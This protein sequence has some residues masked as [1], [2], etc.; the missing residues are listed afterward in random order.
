MMIK[1]DARYGLEVVEIFPGEYHAT[2]SSRIISTVLGS[3][4]AVALFDRTQPIAGM[5]HFMLPGDLQGERIYATGSGKYGMYAM[6][7]LINDMIKLGGKK[8]NFVAKV[9]GGGSVLRSVSGFTGSIPEGN[10]KFSLTYLKQENIPIAT[11][12]VGGTTGRR[13]LYFTGDHKV[14]VRKLSS[15]EVSPVENEEKV[16]LTKIRKEE[17]TKPEIVLF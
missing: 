11:S 12:D 15:Q 10:I 9:F 4:V 16:Y 5:N 3:C 1:W 8:A 14:L 2:A 17:E 7:L 6:E 13:V